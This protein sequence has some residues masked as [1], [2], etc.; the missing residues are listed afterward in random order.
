[1]AIVGCREIAQG[2]E[3]EGRA[4]NSQV[5]SRKKYTSDRRYI[6][7]NFSGKKQKSPFHQC[8]QTQPESS[9]LKGLTG[10]LDYQAVL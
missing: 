9:S 5:K 6:E 4:R 2:N 10:N 8:F 7:N 3:A 1:M